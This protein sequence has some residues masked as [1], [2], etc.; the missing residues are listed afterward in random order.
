MD[1]I[2]RATISYNNISKHVS[3]YLIMSSNNYFRHWRCPSNVRFSATTIG[4]HEDSRGGIVVGDWMAFNNQMKTSIPHGGNGDG[5]GDSEEIVDNIV[6][7]R[8][9]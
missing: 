6:G 4:L 1:Y 5:E 7:V 3:A 2:I 9:Q 8:I